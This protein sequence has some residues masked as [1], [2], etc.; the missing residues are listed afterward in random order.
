LLPYPTSYY[1]DGSLNQIIP[2]LCFLKAVYDFF[3]TYYTKYEN[4][5][6]NG[7]NCLI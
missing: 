4:M 7:P 1:S 2:G 3:G 6:R 5:L